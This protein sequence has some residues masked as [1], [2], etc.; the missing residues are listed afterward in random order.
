MRHLDLFRGLTSADGRLGFYTK[1][2][3]NRI[4]EFP[5]CYAWFLPL[6]LYRED[7]DGLMQIVCG[8]LSYDKVPEKEVDAP[9]TWESIKLRVRRRAEIRIN[10]E[11]RTT[12]RRVLANDETKK[13]LQ[14]ILMEAS[15]LMPPLYIGRTNN[16]KRRYLEHTGTGRAHFSKN[17]FHF[18]FTEHVEELEL[19]IGISDLLFA[20]IE[21]QKDLDRNFPDVKKDDF[22]VLIEQILMQFCR[23]PFSLR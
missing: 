8:L 12:W 23:P 22:N 7:L 11:I 20:C 3:R 2:S 1:E 17:N 15:L 13:A 4:P 18:R 16:L 19:K 9:F 10:D 21:T 5:G 14:Q 6:W